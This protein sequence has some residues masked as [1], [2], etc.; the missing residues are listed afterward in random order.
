MPPVCLFSDLNHAPR[1]DYI[2]HLPYSADDSQRLGGR[3]QAYSFWASPDPGNPPTQVGARPDRT[4][5]GGILFG[6]AF[7]SNWE[8]DAFDKS[9]APY[10]HPHSFYF[11]GYPKD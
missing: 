9:A 5:D 6:Y 2:K 4:A 7:R 1:R 10:R 11:S 8:P 3:V